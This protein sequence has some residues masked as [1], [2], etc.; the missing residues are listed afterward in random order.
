MSTPLAAVI[1]DLDG[2]LLDHDAAAEAALRSWLPE[3]SLTA[4]EIDALVPLWF[5]AEERHYPAWRS[6]EISFQEQ[7]RR[8]LRDFLPAAGV[9]VDE[10]RL[11]A[12]F[13]GYLTGYE[14][15]WRAYDDARDALLRVQDAGLAV[16]VLTNGDGDQ[17]RS[18][19]RATGLADLCGTVFASAELP[20][21]KPDPRAYAAACEGLGVDPA[22]TLMVGDNYDLDVVAAR[23]AGLDALHLD[24]AGLHGDPACSCLRDLASLTLAPLPTSR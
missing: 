16:G 1:F 22:Q 11:D 12:V 10:E 17:Q 19:V 14:Q 20:A 3:Y 18:K 23:A 5:A 24:R 13:Q 21:A 2:T 4:E 8:R 9:P 6:G 15:G 7:R